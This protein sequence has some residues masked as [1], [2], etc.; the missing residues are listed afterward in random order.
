M[1]LT[2]GRGW[3]GVLCALLAGI[4]TLNVI[5]LSFAASS[6][7]ITS[8][9]PALEKENSVLRRREAQRYGD[10]PGPLRGRAR[11]A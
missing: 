4:V 5:T 11:S 2:R 7:Q 6:G 10:R 3:I 8:R 1:R 9:S